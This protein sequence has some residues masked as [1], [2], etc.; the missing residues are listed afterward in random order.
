MPFSHRLQGS[1]VPAHTCTSGAHTTTNEDF[2]GRPWVESI[3]KIAMST[4]KHWMC[5]AAKA[6]RSMT[7]SHENVKLFAVLRVLI[8]SSDL[9]HFAPRL[10]R[11]R[12]FQ[13]TRLLTV[14]RV[15]H[16]SR[17]WIVFMLCTSYQA[18]AVG[19]TMSNGWRGASCKLKAN[20]R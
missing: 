3:T 20:A 16:T 14:F 13:R 5:V 6:Q 19:C 18:M 9:L 15:L 8:E 1:G 11:S 10:Q 7:P 17:L 4:E 2:C 12:P